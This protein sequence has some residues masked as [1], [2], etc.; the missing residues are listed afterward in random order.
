MFEKS[1]KFIACLLII[2]QFIMQKV[3][4]EIN[5]GRTSYYESSKH[6]KYHQ[7]HVLR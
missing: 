1:H 3:I 4:G 5:N 7:E 2:N 6:F